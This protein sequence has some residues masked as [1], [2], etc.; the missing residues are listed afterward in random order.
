[1]DRDEHDHIARRNDL[2]KLWIRLHRLEVRTELHNVAPRLSEIVRHRIDEP[3]HHRRLN[4][5]QHT[6]LH[7]RPAL[8]AED[9]VDVGKRNV[10]TE[11][12]DD[13]SLQRRQCKDTDHGRI[14]HGLN[15][16][17]IRHLLD[18]QHLDVDHRAQ[19]RRQIGIQ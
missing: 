11:L 18:G 19:A 16:F 5:R 10:R 8:T 7:A 1:M 15:E 2:G 12:D 13:V 9:A 14:R 3:A 17:L 6:G 4:I